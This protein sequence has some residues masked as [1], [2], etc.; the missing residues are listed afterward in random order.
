MGRKSAVVR[1]KVPEG[2]VAQLREVSKRQG[3]SVSEVI[4]RAISVALRGGV[5]ACS[6]G[7]GGTVVLSFKATPE[8]HQEL[9]RLAGERKVPVSEVVRSAVACYLQEFLQRQRP[10]TGKY[11]KVY[12]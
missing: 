11:I 12:F 1:V 3:T 4:R 2:M 6:Y 10:Y 5:R 7:Y 9:R 8:V